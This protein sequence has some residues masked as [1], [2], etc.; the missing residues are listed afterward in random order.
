MED[1][2][3]AYSQCNSVPWP[4]GEHEAGCVASEGAEVV[5]W[6]LARPPAGPVGAGPAPLVAATAA[7]APLFISACQRPFEVPWRALPGAA[8]PL[9]GHMH[10]LRDKSCFA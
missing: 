8:W 9:P 3:Y 1:D 10:P 4:F 6:R 7:L 2:R 5:A